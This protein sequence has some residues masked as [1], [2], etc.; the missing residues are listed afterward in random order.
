MFGMGVGFGCMIFEDKYKEQLF[1]NNTL[2]N[3]IESHE[4]AYNELEKQYNYDL[5]S[6]HI[7]LESC[8]NVNKDC[9]VNGGWNCE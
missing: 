9:L 7:L 6:C 5:S 8:Q 3:V 4:K 1:I 2:Y